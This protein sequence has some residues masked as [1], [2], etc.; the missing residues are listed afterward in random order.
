MN[1]N[2]IFKF[3]II[4][5]VFLSFYILLISINNKSIINKYTKYLYEIVKGNYKFNIDNSD[6]KVEKAINKLAINNK[7]Y[8]VK[9]AK[10]N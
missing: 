2:D 7:Y 5:T 4:F 3:G 8:Y 1:L 10:K 6:D 9:M